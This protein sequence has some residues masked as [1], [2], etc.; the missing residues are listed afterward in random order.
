M[1]AGF[2]AAFFAGAGAAAALP[3]CRLR[4]SNSVRS[5]TSAPRCDAG[6]SCTRVTFRANYAKVKTE[7]GKLWEK[8]K[9][10]LGT[11]YTWP[12]STYIAEPSR[13]SSRTSLWKT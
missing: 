3:A 10:V 11:A 1:G 2:A 9:G 4:L 8:I 12:T 6:S 5:M 7:P 13:R